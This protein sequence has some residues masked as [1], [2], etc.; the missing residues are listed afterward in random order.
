MTMMI[1]AIVLD[2][3]PDDVEEGCDQDMEE[4]EDKPTKESQQVEKTTGHGDK[5]SY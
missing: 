2:D 4:G 1:T 5:T 3:T